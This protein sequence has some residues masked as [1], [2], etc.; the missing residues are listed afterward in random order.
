MAAAVTE[1]FPEAKYGV[2]PPI[3]GGFFYD[4]AVARPFT[5]EDLEKIEE[6]MKEL[7]SKN[8]PFEREEVEKRDA[9]ARFEEL[10]QPFKR[11]LGRREGRRRRLLLS[12][13]QVLRLLRGPARPRE[14]SHQG[15]QGP[16]QLRRLLEGRRVERPHAADLRHHLL[17]S[18]EPRRA[19]D[20][21][22]RGEEAR[23]PEARAR[24]RPFPSSDRRRRARCSGFRTGCAW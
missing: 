10:G 22:R 14:R 12:A 2:G 24:A 5:P 6:K 4:F 3:E 20:P 19:F 7:A 21:A 1:L 16:R 23:S 17:R 13:R 8:I 18:E 9:V 15:D 11:E